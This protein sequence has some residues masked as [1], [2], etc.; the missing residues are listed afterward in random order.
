M[1]AA[2]SVS[3]RELL[4][5]TSVDQAQPARER[6]AADGEAGG[7]HLRAAQAEG[8]LWQSETMYS[9]RSLAALT[10]ELLKL[11]MSFRPFP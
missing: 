2:T 11:K 3:R 1:A 8:S 7:P 6:R 5:D 4:S 10:L 9:L